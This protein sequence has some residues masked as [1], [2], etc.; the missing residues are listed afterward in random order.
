M[1]KDKKPKKNKKLKMTVGIVG[2]ILAILF[3]F[4]SVMAVTYGIGPLVTLW[5]MVL[6]RELGKDQTIATE[7][8]TSTTLPGKE[9][10]KSQGDAADGEYVGK[11]AEEIKAELEKQQVYVTA[12]VSSL[13]TFDSGKKGAEGSWIVENVP[14]ND[15]VQQAEIYLGDKCVARSAVI[16]PG[17]HIDKV[18]LMEDVQPGTYDV[19]AYLNYFIPQTEE[20]ISKAG[21]KI[22]LTVK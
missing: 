11:T 2:L 21:F 7:D 17:Q 14:E 18:K 5:E 8:T 10:D 13:A 22:T 16:Y 19:T 1:D 20:Y 9:L 4:S 3:T 6:G 12:A 15:V